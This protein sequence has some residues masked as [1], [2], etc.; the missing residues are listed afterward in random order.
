MHSEAEAAAAI[1]EGAD[2]LLVGNVYQTA[3]HPGRPP[4][5]LDLVR[6]AAAL[7][8]PVIA[9]G[10]IDA[11]PR[12]EAARGRRLRRRGHRARSGA[13]PTPPRRRWPCS[14]PGLDDA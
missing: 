13:R 5:G 2:F 14:R 3:S 10:G 8:R 9:I 12:A 11:G 6:A 4:A 7:G 1:A